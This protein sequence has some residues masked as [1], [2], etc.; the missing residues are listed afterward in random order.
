MNSSISL[1]GIRT[2]YQKVFKPIVPSKTVEKRVKVLERRIDELLALPL[3]T[4]VVYSAGIYQVDIS[5]SIPI[6]A[7][8]VSGRVFRLRFFV[9]R[10]YIRLQL[11]ILPACLRGKGYGREIWNLF[12]EVWNDLFISYEA[13]YKTGAA[14][15]FWEEM[16][17]FVDKE[18]FT[19]YHQGDMYTARK[20]KYQSGAAKNE[21][22]FH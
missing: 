7:Q 6:G 15:A 14:K 10:H 13:E 22:F 3:E 21:K 16:G 8:P 17:F 20:M 2:V 5:Q 19:S 1:E 18:S 9:H 12:L 11:L 4:T